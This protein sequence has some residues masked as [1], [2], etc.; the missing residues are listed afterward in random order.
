MVGVLR[1]DR[2]ETFTNLV[3]AGCWKQASG[4]RE[5]LDISHQNREPLVFAERTGQLVQ[6]CIE[7]FPVLGLLGELSMFS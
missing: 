6:E 7:L 3:Q 1:M 4:M 2:Q 5:A